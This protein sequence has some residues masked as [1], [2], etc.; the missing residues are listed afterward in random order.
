MLAPSPCQGRVRSQDAGEVPAA[1]HSEGRPHRG[2]RRQEEQE[3]VL[4]ALVAACCYDTWLAVLE[5]T[6]GGDGEIAKRFQRDS[7]SEGLRHRTSNNYIVSIF[8]TRPPLYP[9]WCMVC[10][11]HSTATQLPPNCLTTASINIG[12]KGRSPTQ[13][14]HV[15]FIVEQFLTPPAD[16]RSVQ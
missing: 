9:P 1:V 11:C 3:K 14:T 7:G 10:N 5:L 13:G 12:E 16:M 15:L 8:R 4:R 6:R 2:G